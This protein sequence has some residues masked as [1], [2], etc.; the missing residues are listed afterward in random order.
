MFGAVLMFLTGITNIILGVGING[1]TTVNNPTFSGFFL[2]AFF[3]LFLIML[4]T[5]ANDK[6][7]NIKKI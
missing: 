5:Y 2:F 1:G 7:K 6:N 3:G 4:G